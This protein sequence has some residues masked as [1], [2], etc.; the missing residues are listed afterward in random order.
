MQST[1]SK[2]EM[3][4]I[5]SYI[6]GRHL[7]AGRGTETEPCSV[8][9]INLALTGKLTD[10][11]PGCMS[12][13]IGAVVIRL[14]GP[15]PDEMRNSREWRELLPLAAGTGRDPKREKERAA[16]ALEWMW[17]TVLPQLQPW[18]ERHGFGPEWA[19]MCEQRTQEAAETARAAA[20]SSSW[21]AS[22]AAS[23][24]AEAA[25]WA[26]EAEWATKRAAQRATKRAARW[27]AEAGAAACG[28]WKAEAVAD[29]WRRVDPIGLLRGMVAVSN[30]GGSSASILTQRSARGTRGPVL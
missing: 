10:D 3:D 26:A 18:A 24:A 7:G 30:P 28:V 15:M 12:Q 4:K 6:E 14:Q 21:V 9:A 20:A 23:W 8:A 17:S 1:L 16:I 11:V 2:K 25:R 27:A 19:A 29:F 13:V 22:S 5:A